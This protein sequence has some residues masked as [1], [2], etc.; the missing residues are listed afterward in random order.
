MNFRQNFS[1]KKFSFAISEKT[2]AETVHYI[3][4]GLRKG[5]P[6]HGP[7]AQLSYKGD[8]TPLNPAY[9]PSHQRLVDT[10]WEEPSTGVQT[11]HRSN[12]SL[13]TSSGNFCKFH[14]TYLLSLSLKSTNAPLLHLL[15]GLGNLCFFSSYFWWCYLV[16]APEFKSNYQAITAI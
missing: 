5:N 1:Q 16:A 3:P 13:P 12:N 10:I 8:I 7:F 2:L 9:H 15:C 14:A 11:L 6:F 4:K